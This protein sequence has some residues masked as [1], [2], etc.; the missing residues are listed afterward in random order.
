MAWKDGKDFIYRNYYQFVFIV[1]LIQA[2]LFYL[3]HYFWK[4]IEPDILTTAPSKV[5]DAMF[6][7]ENFGSH[8]CSVSD[9]SSSPDECSSVDESQLKLTRIARIIRRRLDTANPIAVMYFLC[10]I[11]AAVNLSL[12]MYMLDV[13][14]LGKFL[15]LGLLVESYY[16]SDI[17]SDP[18]KL[19]PLVTICS[20][21]HY[22]NTGIMETYDVLCVLPF[23]ALNGK[24]FISMWIWFSILLPLTLISILY[25]LLSIICPKFRFV[26]YKVSHFFRRAPY[27]QSYEKLLMHESFGAWFV[28]SALKSKIDDFEFSKL[29]KNILSCIEEEQFSE[30]ESLTE[31]HNPEEEEQAL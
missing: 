3:P 11:L 24:V 10:E 31:T 15:K 4:T 30:V 13:L 19:F 16:N 9:E 8:D 5:Q 2:I 1:L 22:G 25:F 20:L 14:F 21:H 17:I 18:L 23:N 26:A 12:Q 27:D 7:M 28:L 29:T 6:S